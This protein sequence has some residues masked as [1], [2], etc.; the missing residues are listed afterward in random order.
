MKHQYKRRTLEEAEKIAQ[1]HFKATAKDNFSA[2][3]IKELES[4]GI[5]TAGLPSSQWQNIL[6]Y[7]PDET[8]HYEFVLY[9]PSAGSPFLERV[10]ASILVIRDR[11]SEFCKI[12]WLPE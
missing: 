3:L 9:K 11:S 4:D 12:V 1:E 5:R 2:E 7:V 10:Y 8:M 6:G